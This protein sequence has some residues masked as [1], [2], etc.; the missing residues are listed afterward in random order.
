MR[1]SFFLP[2]MLAGTLAVSGM[3]CD[4]TSSKAED[5]SSVS[6]PTS[7]SALPLE[8]AQLVSSCL[9][10]E[11]T[12]VD[13]KKAQEE[14]DRLYSLP[15]DPNSLCR[16]IRTAMEP[17]HI[18]FKNCIAL[19]EEQ[20]GCTPSTQDGRTTLLEEK[21]LALKSSKIAQAVVDM[22]Q[23]IGCKSNAEPATPNSILAIREEVWKIIE[24]ERR[25]GDKAMGLPGSD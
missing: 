24:I 17:A 2:G 12:K 8:R 6:S 1:K 11:K 23:G 9:D 20:I 4:D 3:G 25:I 22:H 16:E 13:C 7:S 5:T 19:L 14:L 15:Q 18:A 10:P 21:G